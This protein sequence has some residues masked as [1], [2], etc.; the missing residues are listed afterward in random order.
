MNIPFKKFKNKTD[1]LIVI[2]TILIIACII[3]ILKNNLYKKNEPDNLAPLNNDVEEIIIP[4]DSDFLDVTGLYNI[5]NETIGLIKINDTLVN[6]PIVQSKDNE[7]YL[8]NSFKKE[9]NLEGTIFMDYRNSSNL[10]DRNTVIYG[11]NM[12]GDTMFGGLRFYRDQ[13]YKDLHSTFKIYTKSEIYEYEIFSVYVTEPN[14]DYRTITFN[15]DSQFKD[16]ITRITSKSIITSNISP[17][18]DDKIVTLSTCAFD[19][20]DARLAIHAILI[21]TKSNSN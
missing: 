5:N 2:S 4:H 12:L 7:F 16:F 10:Q 1:F 9:K 6:Y 17:K 19:F 18:I 8:T 13:A 11:H 14:F 15:D 20:Q 21:N 3:I